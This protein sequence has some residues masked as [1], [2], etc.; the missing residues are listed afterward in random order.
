MLK[1][2]TLSMGSILLTLNREMFAGLQAVARKYVKSVHF[3][4]I[5]WPG[6]RWKVGTLLLRVERE[7]LLDLADEEKCMP[8]K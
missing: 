4:K 5:Y 3:H 8:A 7:N 2:L 1:F 6:N